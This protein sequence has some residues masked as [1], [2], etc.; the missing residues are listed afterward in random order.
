MKV[1]KIICLM[2]LSSC[3]SKP[4]YELTRKREYNK[5]N[6]GMFTG[7]KPVIWGTKESNEMIMKTRYNKPFFALVNHFAGQVYP[8]SCG[9]ASARIVLS[10]IYERTHTLF[11][12]DEEHSLYKYKNGNDCGKFIVSERNV[13]DVYQ[14]N[15]DEYDYDVIARQKKHN[16]KMANGEFSGGID[17]EKLAYIIDLHKPAK[18]TY[19]EVKP[20]NAT[21]DDINEF[22]KVI[23]DIMLS[24]G[25]Y[26][27]ANYH[28]GAMYPIT[29]GHFS[30][31]VAYEPITDM[32]LIMDVASHLGTWSWIKFEELYR[33]M[34]TIVNGNARGYIIIEE[35]KDIENKINT[36]NR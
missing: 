8:T 15:E 20:E 5:Y 25:K 32:V 22:R 13:F 1:I 36:D 18:A 29:S 31:V 4:D 14:G 26:M 19:Y 33:A 35:A 27:I 11:P 10:A 2:L 23:K 3:I 21:K 9:P 28:L 34:N 30:P 7:T 24:E 16:C 6:Y 12:I 17:A